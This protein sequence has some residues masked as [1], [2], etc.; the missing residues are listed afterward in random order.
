MGSLPALSQGNAAL[1]HFE[2]SPGRTV[3][4]LPYRTIT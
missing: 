1:P 3:G 2:F 4:F